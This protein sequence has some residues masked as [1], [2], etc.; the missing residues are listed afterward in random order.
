MT[1]KISINICTHVS[2]KGLMS[3]VRPQIILKK[4]RIDNRIMN[5][6]RDDLPYFCDSFYARTCEKSF[7][8][9]EYLY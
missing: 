1:Q 8:F 3:K 9:L 6:I 5:K 2:F 7:I 4:F